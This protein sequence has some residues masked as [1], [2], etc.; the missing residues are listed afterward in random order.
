MLI[1]FKLN[2]AAIFINSGNLAI[3]PSSF[4]ISTK[5]PHGS[6]PANIEIST[7]ASVWP[8][9]RRTPPGLDFKGKI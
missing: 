1:I 3:V 4:K 6:N 2:L 7:V 5:T 9:R 8:V